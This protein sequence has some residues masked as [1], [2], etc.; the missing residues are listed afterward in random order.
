MFSATLFTHKG[1]GLQ[2]R[3]A[4]ALEFLFDFLCVLMCV[5]LACMSEPYVYSVLR[6]QQTAL[7]PLELELQAAV[8]AVWVL[9]IELRA[10]E[11]LPQP[12]G[13]PV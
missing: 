12:S 4:R 10:S 8:S 2:G 9:G 3:E 5:Y 11:P 6:S 1:E 7:D 13:L